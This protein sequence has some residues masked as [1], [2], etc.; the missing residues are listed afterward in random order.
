[1]DE[2]LDELVEL[3]AGVLAGVLGLEEV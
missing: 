2:E 3:A 1:L